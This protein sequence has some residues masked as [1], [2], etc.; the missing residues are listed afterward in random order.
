VVINRGTAIDGDLA[1]GDTTVVATPEPVEVTIVGLA[2]VGGEDGIGPSTFT[3]FSLAGAEEH[4]TGRPGEV[5]ALLVQA[6]N[7]TSQDAL[8]DRI[9]A[10]APGDV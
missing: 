3:A 4:I 1:V 8:A 5:T 9:A 10:V 6:S 7:G 2:T